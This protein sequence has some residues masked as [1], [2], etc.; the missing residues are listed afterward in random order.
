[1]DVCIMPDIYYD[2][3][4]QPEI[5]GALSVSEL[6]ESYKE[7]TISANN[8]VCDWKLGNLFFVGTSPAAAFTVD[9]INV[10][11]TSLKMTTINVMVTQGAVGYAPSVLKINGVVTATKYSG[12][13]PTATSGAGKIDIYTF[14]LMRTPSSSWNVFGTGSLNFG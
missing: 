14:T 1:M 10:P 2:D 5:T 11:E 7:V 8:L 6:T 4:S 9:I 12:T 3:A 13:A